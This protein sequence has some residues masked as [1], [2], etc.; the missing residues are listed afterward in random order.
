MNFGIGPLVEVVVDDC[1]AQIMS[2]RHGMQVA[3]EMEV[4]VFHR[5]DLG[6]TSP[7]SASFHPHARSE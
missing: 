1:R 5:E 4:D 7:G 3:S 2:H 6:I